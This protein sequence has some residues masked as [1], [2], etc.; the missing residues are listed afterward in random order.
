MRSGREQ[1]KRWGGGG[2][3]LEEGEGWRRERSEG[4]GKWRGGRWRKSPHLH[5]P[6]FGCSLF[7]YTVGME[8]YCVLFFQWALF[9]GIPSGKGEGETPLIISYHIWAYT[10]LSPEGKRR[11]GTP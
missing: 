4:V 2:G 11:G 6:P 7:K 9:G 3:G 10:L 1:G 8:T 5:I